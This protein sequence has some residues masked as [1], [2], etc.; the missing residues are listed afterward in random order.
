MKLLFISSFVFFLFHVGVSQEQ[1]SIPIYSTFTLNSKVLGESRTI[2]VWTPP[3]YSQNQIALPVMYMPDGGIKED[4]PHIANTMA[5]LIAN[6][7]IPT[8]IL[9][10]I[11]NTERRR[12]LTG[13]TDSKKDKKIA[14]VVGGSDKFRSF[15][16]DELFTEI[17]SRYLITNKKG[18]IGESLAGL[19]IMETLFLEP[20]MFDYYIAIDPSLW[21]NS[22][23]LVNNAQMYLSKAPSSPKRLWFAGSSVKDI[24][25]YTEKLEKLLASKTIQNFKWK[26]S[27]EPL[28]KHHTIYRA[29]KEKALI[30][31][32][33]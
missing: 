29:T 32:L 18:I 2:N 6:K 33:N 22:H 9:V 23:F 31:M 16:R 4:F 19:F 30:W 26:Y 17:N 10:G 8:M 28:E 7:Q 11:E 25:K 15:I 24:Y 3:V 13:P 27:T 21:W 14:P 1:D 5:E 12:D 20:E